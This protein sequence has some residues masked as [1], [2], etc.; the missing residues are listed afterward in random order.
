MALFSAENRPDKRTRTRTIKIT[1]TRS[2]AKPACWGQPAPPHRIHPRDTQGNRPGRRTRTIRI[3]RTREKRDEG[4]PPP[5]LGPLCSLMFFSVAK[6][7]AARN[8]VLRSSRATLPDQKKNAG[9]GRSG[10]VPAVCGEI[11]LAA[12]AGGRCAASGSPGPTSPCRIER[13][14]CTWRTGSI[15]RPR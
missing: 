15:P 4:V 8:S 11:I 12:A 14:C 1:R 6:T 10:V 13:G 3:T 9:P 7:I 5:F 2:T